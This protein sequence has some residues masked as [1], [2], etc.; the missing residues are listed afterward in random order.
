MTVSGGRRGSETAR[1]A[2][3]APWGDNVL[4]CR[5]GTCPTDCRTPC[6]T[7]I[8]PQGTIRQ[9]RSHPM[10]QATALSGSPQWPSTPRRRRMAPAW[11]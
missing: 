8:E 7:Q 10:Y 11:R 5:T 9:P 6:H 2:R 4:G 1:D 3:Q